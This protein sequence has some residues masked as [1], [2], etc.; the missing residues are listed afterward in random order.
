MGHE[1]FQMNCRDHVHISATE[2]NSVGI[3]VAAFTRMVQY[4]V[5]CLCYVCCKCVVK[6]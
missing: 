6:H 2:Q 4:D 1:E 3:G 5:L